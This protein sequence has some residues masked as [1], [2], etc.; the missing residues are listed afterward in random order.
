MP[1]AGHVL[2]SIGR[3]NAI[4]EY[5]YA[6]LS[7]P[8]K[9]QGL[10]PTDF[11]PVQVQPDPALG[12]IVVTNDKGIGARGPG[13]TIDKG[14]KTKPGKAHNTYDDTGSVTMFT[15]PPAGALRP[16]PRP[17]SP[18]TPGTWSR[19]SKAARRTRCPR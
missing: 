19:R 12:K 8:L 4:A 15:L 11:Y 5:R 3:E 17:C 10:I 6:G 9:Y 2:V 16:T 18:T 14:P 13:S 1:N 7:K